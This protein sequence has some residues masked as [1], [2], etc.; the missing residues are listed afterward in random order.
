MEDGAC[1]LWNVEAPTRLGTAILVQQYMAFQLG[2]ALTIAY[3]QFGARGQDKTKIGVID[4]LIALICF[5]VLMYA[6]WNFSWLLQEQAYR[7]WQITVIGAVV[8]LAVMEG[9]R[10][11]AGFMLFAIVSVFLVYALFA[12]KIPG[13]LIGKELSPERLVQYVGFDP[14]AVFSTPLA[15]GTVVVMLFVFFGQLLFAAG[16]GWVLRPEGNSSAVSA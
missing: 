12:D 8:T 5:G 1:I 4:G 14:S 16:G 6:A 9:V 13:R 7:P 11:K 3:L 10:R 2:L 15:V